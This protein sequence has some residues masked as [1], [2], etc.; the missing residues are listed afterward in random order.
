MCDR[1]IP[2][3]GRIFIVDDEEGI[4]N[5]LQDILSE[6][7]EVSL[8]DSGLGAMEAM[9]QE[10]F[11]LCVCDLRMPEVDGIDLY[12]WICREMPEHKNDFIFIT[13]DTFGPAA[14]TFLEN[15]R[16]KYLC[17]PFTVQ[18]IESLV[19]EHFLAHPPS[20]PAMG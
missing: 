19:R 13:G 20:C 14:Q 11:D 15:A 3:G 7:Y 12:H 10:P 17:K 2:T 16:Q 8:F 18:Q 9:K 5:L 1:A 4:R 6:D